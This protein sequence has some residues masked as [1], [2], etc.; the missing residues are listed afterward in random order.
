MRS[1]QFLL[2][3]NCIFLRATK[4]ASNVPGGEVRMTNPRLDGSL[5][6]NFGMPLTLKQLPCFNKDDHHPREHSNADGGSSHVF[7][8]LDL[9]VMAILN[10]IA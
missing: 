8:D 9:F 4:A 5:L 10:E 3:V 1:I 2:E 6:P 7:N